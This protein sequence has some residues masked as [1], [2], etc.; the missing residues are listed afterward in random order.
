MTVTDRSGAP[1]R[2]GSDRIVLQA[3]FKDLALV[4]TRDC[5]L[6]LGFYLLS[7]HVKL[8]RSRQRARAEYLT[9]R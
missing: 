1:R 8:C 9:A 2:A 3:P 4:I 5:F 6:E 7:S